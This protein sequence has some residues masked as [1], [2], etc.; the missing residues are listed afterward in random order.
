MGL[1]TCYGRK[2]KKRNAAFILD[3]NTVTAVLIVLKQLA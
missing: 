3:R 2:N 1:L